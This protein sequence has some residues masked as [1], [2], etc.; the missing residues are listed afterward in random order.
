M[1][2]KIDVM[3]AEVQRM[4]QDT[5]KLSNDPS[6]DMAVIT[7]RQRIDALEER[8]EELTTQLEFLAQALSDTQE[9][10]AQ[11]TIQTNQPTNGDDHDHN[12][13]HNHNHN[14]G[15]HTPHPR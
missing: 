4:R 15:H 10:L 14:H 1:M 13:N 2:D 5:S 9:A 12:H 3:R 6:G 11:R 7:S 8:V